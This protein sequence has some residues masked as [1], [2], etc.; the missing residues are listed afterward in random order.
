[1]PRLN[2]GFVNK[3]RMDSQ[4]NGGRMG[5]RTGRTSGPEVIQNQIRVFLGLDGRPD[6][7][8]ARDFPG[9]TGDRTAGVI[10]WNKKNTS[11]INC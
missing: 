2:G 7:A 8:R 10:M 6:Q 1:P 4:T 11:K 3:D 5:K 9:P